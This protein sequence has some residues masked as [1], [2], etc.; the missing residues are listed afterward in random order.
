MEFLNEIDEPNRKA[1]AEIDLGAMPD[2]AATLAQAEPAAQP[3]V[4]Q[5]AGGADLLNVD[6]PAP[7]SP[8]RP[9]PAATPSRR[10]SLSPKDA[11]SQRRRRTIVRVQTVRDA[12]RLL[13]Y[14]GISDD[15]RKDIARLLMG[16]EEAINPDRE[17]G[18]PSAIKEPDRILVKA[19]AEML[20]HVE[21]ELSPIEDRLLALDDLI[22]REVFRQRVQGGKHSAKLLARY[23]RLLASRRFPAGYRRDRFEWLA[24]HLLTRTDEAGLKHLVARDRARA[25]LQHLV[26]GLPHKVNDAELADALNYLRDA[27]KK[28]QQFTAP[29]GFFE[30]GYYLD[31]HGYKV[32]M[33]DQLLNADFL[34]LSAAINA[35]LHN[36]LETWIAEREEMHQA[37]RLTREGSPRE[38]IMGLLRE[39]EETVDNIF[40]VK[41]QRPDRATGTKREKGEDGKT[42]KRKKKK[43]K[44]KKSLNIALDR[45][46]AKVT[47][48]AAVILG[49]AGFLLV[50]TEA[51]GGPSLE[52][53]PT[54]TLKK[55]SDIVLRAKIQNPGESG[56]VF[57]TLHNGKWKALGPRERSQAADD[58]L[59]IVK[60]LGLK[61]GAAGVRESK[62]Q[63]I[64]SDGVVTNVVGGK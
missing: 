5:G 58:L 49:V 47:I 55:H 51:V 15:D 54:A 40:G 52:T 32:S 10:P 42:K 44:A 37:N 19:P 59:K 31:V 6:Q 29:E 17:R 18:G 24:T 11:L 13:G 3:T 61:S 48:L 34:Y 35:K 30:S 46:F 16:L 56:H 9:E 1:S 41:R 57:L 7:E 62:P 8:T 39:Q 23:G 28:L 2:V 12:F 38:Q 14:L 27:L 33:R 25:V 63:V 45:T 22:P 20:D 50:E 26:G 60:E 43:K 4:D 36:L 21:T 64:I 53:V